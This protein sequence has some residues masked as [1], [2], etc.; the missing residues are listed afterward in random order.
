MQTGP[1]SPE[2]AKEEEE[3]VEEEDDEEE[4]EEDGGE[5]PRRERERERRRRRRRKREAA[6][7]ASEVVMVKRELLARCMT[8]PLCRRILRDA[9]TVSE[10][11]HTFC[12]KC[13]YKK[14]NDEE[15][16]H[17]PVCK[18][19]LGCAPL[20][21]LRADHNIQD[22]RSK[23]FPLKRKK[24]NAEEVESPIAP[25]AKRKERSISSLV[26]NTPEITPKS[27]TGRRTRASTRKSAAALRDLGPI[28]PP[29][30]KDSDNT[31]KNADNSS[32]LDSL[33]KV[34]Q[35]RRQ[36]LSN[37]ETSSHP[38]SKDKGGDD[39]DL[40]KSELWR[41][42]NCLVEAASKTKSYRS[43]S[44]ARGNQPTESPSSANA[45]RTKAREYL[46]KSKVQDE[47]KEVPVAT[48]PFKRKG[49]GRGRKPAQPPAAAVSSHSASKHEKLLTPVWFSLIASFDQKGAPPLPQ[50]PTHYLR[51]KD[52]NMPA[53]SIQK[54]IM[55]KLSLPSETEVE[56]SCCGQPVNPIQPLRNLIERWLRFGP[57][58]TL[59][60]VVGSSG[61][62]YVMVIS[63]G[64]PKAA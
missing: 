9:T 18:I 32:L 38:S 64:R 43:S 29:V 5:Q 26:V 17:C 48:V 45:S 30:K 44:A 63:Y 46:L 42:L 57:A 21:K 36:V 2:A 12:R 19:D 59:Q 33:S 58:R 35:T 40:D 24:V 16:E 23:I 61:G 3:V 22:V 15:L 49:P 20:E 28:I 53:S 8:C 10:C 31:N 27:L 52:D 56:I 39:K 13:I 4:G 1:A 51:I 41:P 55:Q 60:T 25:P 62:D 47:K 14:I 34:P 11:L 37:A 50:I 54:Y 6:A 7:A